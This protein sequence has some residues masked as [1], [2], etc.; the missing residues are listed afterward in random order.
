MEISRNLHPQHTASD[1]TLVDGR[2]CSHTP[3][4]FTPKNP[5]SYEILQYLYVDDGAFPFG[6]WR[7]LQQWMELIHQHFGRF[8][9]EMHIA[10]TKCVF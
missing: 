2:I 6:T 3:A 9:L 5:T 8:R 1:K 10:Q 4:M 7:D